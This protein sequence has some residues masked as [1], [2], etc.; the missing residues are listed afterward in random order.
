[1]QRFL[2]GCI[3]AVVSLAAVP[4]ARAEMRVGIA[5]S[6]TGS[7]AWAGKETRA[8][9]EAALQ[10]LND[11]GGVLGEA[12]VTILVDDFCDAQPAVAGATFRMRAA[13]TMRPQRFPKRSTSYDGSRMSAALICTPSGAP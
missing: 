4:V 5:V 1:M 2:T 7:H 10:D 6:L 9:A 11:R 12:L 13:D 8:G 3:V